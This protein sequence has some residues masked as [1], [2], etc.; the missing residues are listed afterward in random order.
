MITEVYF[1][2][3]S[4]G[5]PGLSAA[6]IFIKSGGHVL[7][8]SYPLGTMSN[9]EAEF[10]AAKKALELCMSHG[11]KVVSLKTDSQLVCDAIDN[12]FV[13]QTVYAA[14]L[15]PILEM[16]DGEFDHVFIKW[17]AS[18]QNKEADALSKRELFKN[19]QNNI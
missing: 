13:K 12:R 14:Y 16:I 19:R 1:D 2:G 17:I 8:Y 4:A 15:E 3:A 5:N 11:Y 6:G 18:A 7:R 9:H 10:A